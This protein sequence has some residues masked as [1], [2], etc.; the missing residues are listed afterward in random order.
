MVHEYQY[1]C[2][3]LPLLHKPIK[4]RAMKTVSEI[5]TA[6]AKGKFVS[7]HTLEQITYFNV[8]RLITIET[9]NV[10]RYNLSALDYILSHI[11]IL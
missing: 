6:I 3:I 5:Q 11:T 1:Q 9:V 4:H 10:K 2:F 7:L 8:G